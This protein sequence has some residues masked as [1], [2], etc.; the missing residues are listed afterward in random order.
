MLAELGYVAFALD[1]YGEKDLA[2]DRAKALVRSL[3]SDL[4][5]LRARAAAA[6]HQGQFTALRHRRE[7]VANAGEGG[8]LHAAAPQRTSS[9]R[10]SPCSTSAVALPTQSPLLP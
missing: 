5:T 2:I 8:K 9:M 3:R 1:L 10:P 4:S 6:H 7:S